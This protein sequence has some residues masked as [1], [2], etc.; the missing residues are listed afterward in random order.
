MV[1]AALR[2]HR[3]GTAGMPGIIAEASPRLAVWQR[4]FRRLSTRII[5]VAC[6]RASALVAFLAKQHREVTAGPLT[7]VHPERV[8]N[9]LLILSHLFSRLPQC[10]FLRH[11]RAYRAVRSSD[12]CVG[13]R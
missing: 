2:T 11:R 7:R 9:I 5:A 4:G 3:A 12:R 8:R 13:Y 1:G 6:I 10:P